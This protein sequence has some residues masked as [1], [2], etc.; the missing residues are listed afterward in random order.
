MS[1]NDK[2]I[3]QINCL[4][5]M[6]SK[7]MPHLSSVE[8]KNLEQLLEQEIADMDKAIK[9]AVNKIETLLQTSKRE[10]KDIKLEV[11]SNI[12]EQSSNLM[13]AVMQLGKLVNMLLSKKIVF[14]IN[15]LFLFNSIL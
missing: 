12:L 4:V 13:K 8:S 5:E 10:D 3:E 1:F 6:K 15:N 14:E 11:N 2:L 9:E 7:I